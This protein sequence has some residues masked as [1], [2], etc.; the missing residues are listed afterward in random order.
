MQQ[1]YNPGLTAATVLYMKIYIYMYILSTVIFL[2]LFVSNAHAFS[3][4]YIKIFKS[5]WISS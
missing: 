5:N 4:L 2:M 1:K 3:Y